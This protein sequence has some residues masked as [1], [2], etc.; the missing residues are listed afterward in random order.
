M[1][2]TVTPETTT[3]YEILKMLPAWMLFVIILLFIIGQW[4][5]SYMAKVKTKKL[6][7]KNDEKLNIFIDTTTNYMRSTQSSLNEFNISMNVFKEY[8]EEQ[9]AK[10]D[11]FLEILYEKF[12]N[13]LTLEIA[14]KYIELVFER[15][16]SKILHKITDYLS[17]P[18]KFDENNE[19]KTSC[20]K[21]EFEE[22]VRNRY[23]SDI[24]DLNKTSCKNMS[25]DSFMIQF[26]PEKTASD[27][28][29]FIE[30]NRSRGS[31]DIYNLT[32]NYMETYYTTIINKAHGSLEEQ[33]KRKA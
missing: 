8:Q 25:L 24:M 13:N 33:T 15:T 6:E 9:A 19:F 17:N 18:K 3:I 32:K 11:L 5:I 23:Y 26:N 27:I 29:D 22:F 2:A 16:K 21:K 20:L 7:T 30:E 10:H 28:I 4:I 31:W 14:K 1:I 12:A